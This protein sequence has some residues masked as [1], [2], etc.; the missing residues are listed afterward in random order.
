[1]PYFR[2]PQCALTV[3]SVAGRFTATACPRCSVPLAGTDRIYAPERSPVTLSRRFP[4]IPR[5]AAAARRA[6]ET[7]VWGL[8]AA[9]LQVAALLT[10]DLVANGWSTPA[11]AQAQAPACALTPP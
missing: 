8:D 11:Q 3:Q 10:T 4:A 9:Q 2:C 7:L 5:A 1:M 6:L